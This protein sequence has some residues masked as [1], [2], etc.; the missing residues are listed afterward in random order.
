MACIVYA[1]VYLAVKDNKSTLFNITVDDLNLPYFTTI[2]HQLAFAFSTMGVLMLSLY[3][4]SLHD[5]SEHEKIERFPRFWRFGLYLALAF[6]FLLIAGK[7]ICIY[8][9]DV[10]TFE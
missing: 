9:Y 2:Y 4:A 7:C 5:R 10:A 6:L 8:F 1:P 3:I